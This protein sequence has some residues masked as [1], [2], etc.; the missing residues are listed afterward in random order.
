MFQL[1]KEIIS[2]T[3]STGTQNIDS[4]IGYGCIVL[5]LLGVVLTMDFAYKLLLRFLPKDSK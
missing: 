5:V 4:Y 2:Y 1:L 3:S